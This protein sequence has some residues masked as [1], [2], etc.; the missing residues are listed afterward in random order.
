MEYD[1]RFGPN[2]DF[3]VQ[4][5][6]SSKCQSSIKGGAH[7]CFINTS[8]IHGIYEV[9]VTPALNGSLAIIMMP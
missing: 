6:I 9:L 7:M 1:V 8:D 2:L 4:S 5:A 3:G